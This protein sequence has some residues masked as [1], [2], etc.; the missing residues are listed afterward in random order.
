[1]KPT[2]KVSDKNEMTAEDS[3]FNRLVG[4]IKDRIDKLL[5]S[6][7]N[8]KEWSGSRVMSAPS[9]NIITSETD[10]GL[11]KNIETIAGGVKNVGSGVLGS[12]V[13]VVGDVGTGITN[14]ITDI[15]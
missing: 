15:I 14:V 13:S 3:A 12:V 6:P 11:A 7:F 9:A 4:Q 5:V 8:A 1:M 2:Q 10:T